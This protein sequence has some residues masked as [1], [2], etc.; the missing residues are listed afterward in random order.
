MNKR[1]AKKLAKAR[2]ILYRRQ[3]YS[4]TTARERYLWRREMRRR[5]EAEL[6]QYEGV[7]MVAYMAKIRTDYERNIKAARALSLFV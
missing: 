1:I 6:R 7:D 5:L 2:G 3:R 4:P